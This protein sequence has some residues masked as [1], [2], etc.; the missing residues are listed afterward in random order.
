MRNVSI[1]EVLLSNKITDADLVSNLY[2][3]T[4]ICRQFSKQRVLVTA[5]GQKVIK[6]DLVQHNCFLT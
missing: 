3:S 4:E 5:S 6:I 1:L 2:L